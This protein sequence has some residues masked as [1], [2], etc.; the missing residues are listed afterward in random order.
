MMVLLGT[1][2]PTTLAY[3]KHKGTF[4]YRCVGNISSDH[5]WGWHFDLNFNIYKKADGTYGGWDKVTI[6]IGSMVI[7]GTDAAVHMEVNEDTREIWYIV[8][9]E[10]HYVLIYMKDCGRAKTDLFTCQSIPTEN[11]F[12]DHPDA[13][14]L[15]EAIA[16]C[17][18]QPDLSQL[19]WW[20]Q[21]SASPMTI[22]RGNIVLKIY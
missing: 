9:S 15:E 21:G 12:P 7:E 10:G 4:V 3:G 18:S 14:S 11:L 2:I 1:L 19:F 17:D 13:M 16:L 6:T 5:S 20:P 22:H 8:G